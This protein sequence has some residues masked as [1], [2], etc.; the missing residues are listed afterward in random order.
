MAA[1]FFADVLGFSARSRAGNAA[2]AVD[3]LSDLA[4]ILSTQSSVARY[5]QAPAWRRRYGLSDSIFLVTD[6][7]IGACAAAAEIFSNL[8]FYNSHADDA[9]LLRGAI[10]MGAVREAM[11]LS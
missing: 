2:P 5:L 11:H 3:A 7:P 4:S 8:A 10:T 9:V 1:V 6:D